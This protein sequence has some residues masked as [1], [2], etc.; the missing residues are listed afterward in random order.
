[1][2]RAVKPSQRVGDGVDVAHA[3]ARERRARVERG[4]QHRHAVRQR[5]AVAVRALQMSKDR[6]DGALGALP[7]FLCIVK[8]AQICL[9]RVRQRIHAGL[10]RD[11]RRQPQRQRRVEHGIAR[12]EAE[13]GNGILVAPVCY[14]GGDGRLR[15]RARRCGHGD[16][17]RDAAADL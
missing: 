7:R 16:E 10:R 8:S 11:V 14:D 4:L 12:D 5:R 9:D 6:N 1:M 17:R 13:I 15:P 2:R 3:R